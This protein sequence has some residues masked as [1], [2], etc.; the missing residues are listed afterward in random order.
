M[1]YNVRDWRK[2]LKG[3]LNM[4][5]KKIKASKSKKQAQENRYFYGALL[6]I[7]GLLVVGVAFALLLGNG[8]GQATTAGGGHSAQI[9]SD[10]ESKFGAAWR[11]LGFV[12]WKYDPND[13][14]FYVDS[15]A[16]S[17]VG[18]D[19]AK[20]RM[21]KAG[22]DFKGLVSQHGGDPKQVYIMFHDEAERM[23]ATYSGASG[24]EVQK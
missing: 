20:K 9:V 14:M 4:A 3:A 16:W 17:K 21:T 10:M 8:G 22:D 15:T 23:L 5:K 1:T 12:R 13:T 7:G 11:G 19:E 6:T 24:V 2:S 18:L